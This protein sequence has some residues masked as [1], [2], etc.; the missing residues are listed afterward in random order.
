MGFDHV[1]RQHG[2]RR[3]DFVQRDPVRA[4]R[5]RLC[6]DHGWLTY[7]A[8]SLSLSTY[9]TCYACGNPKQAPRPDRV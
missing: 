2:D 4:P 9:V 8:A 1:S 5:C 7:H 6:T 3:P